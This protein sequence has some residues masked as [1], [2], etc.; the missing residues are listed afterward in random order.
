MLPQFVIL[1]LAVLLVWLALA[2][3]IAP[4]N[5][6]QQR[7]RR[8]DSDDLSPI[9]EREA[10]EEVA[11]LVRAIN[12]LLARLDQSIGAQ[13]HFLADA[14]HQLKTPLAGPAHAGRTGA[15]RDR[16]RRAR[17]A[18]AEEVAA[19]D[20]P[21]EPARGAHGQPAAGDGARR[22]Q[23]AG[24]RAAAVNLAA[25][26]TRG[27]ARLRAA[28]AGKAHRPRL[29]RPRAASAR[30]ALR[31][32]GQPVLLRELIRNLVDNA[33][34][35]TPARR[36]GDGARARRP[37]RPGGG[38]A[39]RG[40][41]PRHPRGRARAGVPAVLP[42]ARHRG[43]RLAAWAWPSC[44][45]SPTQHG[46]RSRIDDAH[47]RHGRAER[48]GPG[49]LFTLRFPLAGAA[50]GRRQPIE[51]M[52]RLTRVERARAAQQRQQAGVVERRRGRR[53][54]RARTAPRPSRPAAHRMPAVARH[55]Q[56]QCA[57]PWPA[58]SCARAA[59]DRRPARGAGG[60][61]RSSSAP[62][63]CSIT[64]SVRRASSPARS[65]S[66][67]AS[68]AP[69][70]LTA[71]SRLLTSLVRAPSPTRRPMR[72][73][74]DDQRV[75]AG[76]CMALEHGIVARPPSGS[77]CPSR[78]RAGPPD[79]G[80]SM[81]STPTRGQARGNALDVV[82]RDGRAQQHAGAAAQR[83]APRRGA[84]QHGF[85][86]APHRPPRR[87]AVRSAAA[88]VGRSRRATLAPS[89]LAA[90]ASRAG[91]MSR[92]ATG[93]NP[94]SSRRS[95]HRQAHVADADRCRPTRSRAPT[96]SSAS[97]AGS[98]RSTSGCPGPGRA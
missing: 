25:L 98:W 58:A 24:A 59:P 69:A 20:R 9:D 64:S 68:A 86:S 31:L 23:R 13:K 33:L 39:G 28:R 7:I 50:R 19:A 77:S 90:S 60:R 88:S 52:A 36:H 84:E 81:Q 97:A 27:G 35:Y 54:R 2:R 15:A 12:D 57:C 78:A 72:N 93:T 87:S 16:R 76:R 80:A 46:A 48:P 83:R 4:L 1:P 56:R 95:G 40:L 70:R 53:R 30:H 43:R 21:L 67:S 34:Q 51:P 11:P 47:P 5:E 66:A 42:R 75:A 65:A 41:R 61:C 82:R 18:G 73:T 94:R 29:R 85:A 14:A 49:A 92:T 96:I 74:G 55:R 6:L 89:A 45:R 91:S 63:D 79:I 37:V 26:A 8:R 32:I 71:A 3:G 44:A 62:L 10:P 17:P 22:G 38:A